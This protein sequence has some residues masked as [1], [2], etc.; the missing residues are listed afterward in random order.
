MTRRTFLLVLGV[1]L[2]SSPPA[3][4]GESYRLEGRDSRGSRYAAVVVF[5]EGAGGALGVE[6][7]SWYTRGGT[8]N[9]DA[10]TWTGT[11]RREGALLGSAVLGW[12]AYQVLLQLV[13]VPRALPRAGRRALRSL[14]AR[15]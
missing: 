7:S 4:A 12:A 14:L 1:L 15:T 11:A 6:R 8:E 10:V 13:P 5:E 9:E 3:L 2:C